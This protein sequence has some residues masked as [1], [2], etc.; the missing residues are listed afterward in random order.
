MNIQD[1]SI[2]AN[3]RWE[4]TLNSLRVHVPANNKHGACP[5]CGGSDRFRFDDK[6]GRGTFYCN[7]CGAGDGFSLV[8]KALNLSFNDTVKEIKT[9][10]GDSKPLQ[11]PKTSQ[12]KKPVNA[13]DKAYYILSKA[14]TAF[15]HPYLTRKGIKPYG[16]GVS[17]KGDLVVPILSGKPDHE[18]SSLQFIK[19]D[20]SKQMLGGGKIKGC[21]NAIGKHLPDE[22]VLLCEGFATASTLFE[23]TGLT[24]FYCFNANNL[25]LV[26][27]MLVNEYK[28]KP[29][30][31]ADNDSHLKV[32]VGIEKAKDAALEF[33]LKAF[34]PDEK[35]DF[36]DLMLAKGK[37][38]V[39]DTLV[40]VN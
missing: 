4:S 18:L 3:G 39:V 20:G 19:P 16:I 7:Q 38:A 30:I 9:V 33:G 15:N 13:V 6:E 31:C 21:F 11:T 5:I 34:A 22:T 36:N 27:Q 29:I 32:N 17:V 12:D 23:C 24:T 1:I 14:N 37:Q 40:G 10:L 25:F 28:L 35:G 8:S 2:I 26:A